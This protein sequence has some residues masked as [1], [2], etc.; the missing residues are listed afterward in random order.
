M[1]KHNTIVRI[2]S[3]FSIFYF[4]LYI[5][6]ALAQT[7]K[8]WVSVD[9]L[10]VRAGPGSNF[11]VVARVHQGLKL[12]IIDRRGNWIKVRRPNGVLGWVNINYVSW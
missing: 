5:D 2:I 12:G 6:N 1:K 11:R 7:P 9:S 10:N 4:T 3:L 8:V